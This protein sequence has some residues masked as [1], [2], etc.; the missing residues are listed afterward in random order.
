LQVSPFFLV[1][2][3]VLAVVGSSPSIHRSARAISLFDSPRTSGYDFSL[4][5]LGICTPFF[6]HS[7]ASFPACTGWRPQ[8]LLVSAGFGW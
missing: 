2:F 6:A 8:L 1:F 5:R 4:Y 3:G 7:C